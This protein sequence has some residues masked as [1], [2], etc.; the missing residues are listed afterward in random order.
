MIGKKESRFRQFFNI[1]ESESKLA[2][3]LILPTLIAVL[4][5]LIYPLV[6]SFV[7]SFT[8][9]SLIISDLNFVGFQN[10]IK[11]FKDP[12]LSNSFLVTLRYVILTVFI[13]LVLGIAI[14]L[15][16]KE[17]FI[18]RG[19][20]R[21][22][23][24]IPWATPFVVSGTIWRWMLNPNVGVINLILKKMGV[25]S[26][27]INWLSNR[28]LALPSVVL[29]DVWQGTPF[30]II[31]L[32]AGLQTIPEDLYEAAVVDGAGSF[33]KLISI[34]LPLIKFP[35]LI[36]TILGT[37]FAINQFDLFYIMTRGGPANYTRVATL[38]DWQTV[39]KSFNSS[40]ASAI[41]YLILGLSLIITII[42]IRIL[43]KGER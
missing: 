35:I 41:S 5:I 25:I 7:L 26:A 38:Y 15:A 13:K 14:S 2:F 1:E 33:R 42:Y 19:L 43:V 22:M 36:V 24:I 9:A 27:S 20:A 29:A 17:K 18:G 4:G 40:Y 37:I 21:A 32:L 3:L 30:F 12:I 39:F 8:N 6:Y 31:I 23:M 34:T 10:Y 16:L 28:N 11:A